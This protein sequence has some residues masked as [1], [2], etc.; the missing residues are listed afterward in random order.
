MNSVRS[1]WMAFGSAAAVASLLLQWLYRRRRRNLERFKWHL[2]L[3]A[4]HVTKKDATRRPHTVDPSVSFMSRRSPVF[5]RRGMVSSSQPLATSAGL[6]ILRAG[7]TAV[8]AAVATAAMLCVV[9]PGST[10]LGGDCFMLLYDAKRVGGVNG[11]GKS[12][13]RQSVVD[14]WNP[15][16]ALCVTVPGCVAAWVDAHH[17]YGALPLIE[18]LRP[19]IEAAKYGFP[20]GPMALAAIHAHRHTLPHDFLAD[21][22]TAGDIVSRP[23]MAT[24]LEFI[25]KQGKAGFY[26]GP[27]ARAIVK[28]VSA[29]GGDLAEADLRSHETLFTE[30]IFVDFKGVRVW[31]HAPNAAGLVALL[32]L[33]TLNHIDVDFSQMTPRLVHVLI[34]ALRFAFADGRAVVCDPHSYQ[35]DT[36]RDLLE[37]LG[38][39]RAQQI[40]LD[41]ATAHNNLHSPAVGVSWGRDTVSFQVVDAQGRAVSAVNSTYMPFGSKIVAH[42]FTLQNRGYNFVVGNPK[43]PNALGPSKRPYHTIL[44]CLVTDPNSGDLL[45][46]LTNMGGFMQPQGHVQHIV[47]LF[48]RNLDPQASVDAPR[49]CL[50]N[51]D[52]DHVSMGP[53]I[54]VEPHFGTDFLHQLQHQFGHQV[55]VLPLHDSYKRGNAVGKAQIIACCPKTGVLVAGSDPRADGC[56]LGY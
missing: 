41:K 9:E 50:E 20:I 38:R 3:A 6:A 22:K 2:A 17:K 42:G 1:R 26:Q 27:V 15:T 37:R 16:S 48:C 49:F 25:A 10:D 55:R 8:D 4:S 51:I 28:E 18:V 23:E 11:S 21:A 35:E 12:A 30:P 14:E 39:L 43:H 19:A 7:G 29:R 40:D 34:E 31:E 44:P 45:A 52:K 36:T 24:A 56:A 5:A 13:M 53:T 33:S 32:A 47:N 54:L 46:T